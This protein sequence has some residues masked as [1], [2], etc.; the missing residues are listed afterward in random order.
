MQTLNPLASLRALKGAPLSCLFAL[1]FANQPVGKAWL[2]RMTGYSDKPVA[3]ALDYLNEMGYVTSNGRYESWQIN[4]A[5]IQ[6]PLMTLDTSPSEKALGT[7]D[8]SSRNFSDSIPTTATAL[9]GKEND[10]RVEAVEESKR[11]RNFSDSR[12]LLRSANVGEPMASVLADLDHITPYYI[13]G[14]ILKAKQD[15]IKIGLLIHRI[16]SADPA[17]E[18]NQRYHLLDCDCFYC[19]PFRFSPDHGLLDPADFNVQTFLKPLPPE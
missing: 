7:S 10:N 6:L 1:M 9:I 16:R 13:A 15:G 8:K 4:T 5:A 12:K 18:L 14:H 19:D 11:S 2:S 17:P 3:A